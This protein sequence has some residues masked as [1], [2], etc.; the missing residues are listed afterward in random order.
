LAIINVSNAAQL[1]AAF[2]T[3]KGGDT[4]SLAPGNYGDVSILNLKPSSR[5]IIQSADPENPAHF[6][7]LAVRSSQN[8]TFRDLDLGRGLL[9]DEPEHTQLSFVRNSSTIVFDGNHFHGSLDNNPQNDG[10]GLL[11][12]TVNGLS[13]VN[14]TFEQLMRGAV[15]SRITNMYVGHNQF[16]DMRSDGL[17]TDG[18]K[19]VLIEHNIF[20]G[21]YPLEPDHP[22][23]MQF[24]NLGHASPTENV[25]IRNNMLL[26][27]G[28]YS[29]Q[30]IWISDP[31]TTGFKNF[32]IENNLLFGEGSF[33]G[34]GLNGVV[35]A[36]VSGNTVL[37]PTHDA[38]TM[39]IRVN[40]SSD[41]DLIRNVSEDIILSSTALNVRVIDAVNLRTNP[42]LRA[43]MANA[44][45]PAGWADILMP[46]VGAV[47]PVALG[48]EAPVSGAVS[49]ALSGL[50]STNSGQALQAVP[51]LDESAVTAS[52]ALAPSVASQAL[53]QVAQIVSAAPA[54]DLF[55]PEAPA[56]EMFAP[57]PMLTT[58]WR[59]SW[60]DWFVAL[61]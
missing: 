23:A 36:R 16:L 47:V 2:A 31:G 29:P 8:L 52:D 14:N 19:N 38:K 30:G 53:A 59:H 35:G 17:D 45:N 32:T 24:H 25:T 7:R 50:L 15:V 37:S 3:A 55:A 49:T 44:E 11:V 9:P 58:G 22:D 46:G 40:N 56:V 51:V 41:I 42:E 13:L 1:N 60:Q 57:E 20:K 27:G 5:L 39:W 6:D 61:P 48:N 43:L 12:D 33:N 54:P 34:I 10:Y 4:I 21:F 26:P 18:S 28:A